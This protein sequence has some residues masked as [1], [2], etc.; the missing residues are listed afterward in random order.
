[1]NVED[2]IKSLIKVL[3]MFNLLVVVLGMFLLE[4]SWNEV[5]KY[6]AILNILS[7]GM[8][9]IINNYLWRTKYIRGLFGSIPNING[10]W[11]GI[12]VNKDDG[13]EQESKLIITQRWLNINVETKVERGDS[14]TISSEIINTNDTWKLYFVWEASFDGSSFDGSTIVHINNDENFLDGRY[15]TNAKSTEK[16]CTVGSFKARKVKDL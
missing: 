11:K 3:V 7:L 16:N 15:Y 12:I 8:F 9:F 13:K 5:L 4:S 6:S 10:E 1:V 2:K 14:S